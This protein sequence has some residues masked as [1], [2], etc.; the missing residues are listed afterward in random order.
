[1]FLF[2][3]DI[4]NWVKWGE[5]FQDIDAFSLL[6]KHIFKV[7]GIPLLEINNTTPGTNAVFDCGRFIVKIYAPPETGISRSEYRSEIEALRRASRQNVPAPRIFACGVVVDKY[8]FYYLI[9]EKVHGTE[10]SKIISNYSYDEKFRFVQKINGLLNNIN[11]RAPLSVKEIKDSVLQNK[12][13]DIF[14]ES[15]QSQVQNLASGLKFQEMVYVH[16]DLTGENVI[17]NKDS[18]TIIDFGDARPAPRYYEYPPI[19]FELFNHD[20]EFIS[21]FAQGKKD[22]GEELFLATVIHEFGAYF[23]RDIC[24]NHFNIK[25]KD[26]D[27]IHK[28]KKYINSLV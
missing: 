11:T 3:K 18:M 15:L 13:W 5:A 22:F 1:M 17:L 10:A 28:V 4:S 23:L 14:P 26:L 12:R 27:D 20:K 16:G 2:N 7:E 6:I 25:P 8:E 9:T 21:L 24:T 19:L